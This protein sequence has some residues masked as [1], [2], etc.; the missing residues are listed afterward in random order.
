MHKKKKKKT[1]KLPSPSFALGPVPIHITSFKHKIWTQRDMAGRIM[2][3]KAWPRAGVHSLQDL[4]PDDLRFS[5]CNNDRN[6]VYNKCNMPESSPNHPSSPS[7]SV[8]KLSSTKP[9]PGAKNVWG[10]LV[11]AIDLSKQNIHSSKTELSTLV[12]GWWGC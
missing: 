12:G 8:E 3:R 5:W 10:P 4:M 11:E 6:K 2:R 1:L 7:L 9:V